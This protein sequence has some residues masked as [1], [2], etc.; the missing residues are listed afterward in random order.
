MRTEY[1]ATN[2]YADYE[3]TFGDA[4][5][6]DLFDCPLSRAIRFHRDHVFKQYVHLSIQHCAIAESHNNLLSDDGMAS[7]ALFR[8]IAFRPVIQRS[9]SFFDSQ[10]TAYLAESYFFH[11]I[12]LRRLFSSVNS[13]E[14][15]H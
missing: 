1:I 8:S 9:I 2:L 4:H 12:S 13:N 3:D 5:Y 11:F 15:Y 7:E 6:F 10:R 14:M